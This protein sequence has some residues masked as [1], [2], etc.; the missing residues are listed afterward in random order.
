[1]FFVVRRTISYPII[2]NITYYIELFPMGLVFHY[3]EK[4]HEPCW[5]ASFVFIIKNRGKRL[6]ENR[7]IL[8]SFRLK[9]YC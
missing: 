7:A 9:P 3:Y 4:H 2:Y 6:P 8:P 1:M 5:T